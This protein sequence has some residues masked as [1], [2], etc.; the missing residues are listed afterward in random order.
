MYHCA[1]SRQNGSGMEDDHSSAQGQLNAGKMSPWLDSDG[2]RC[3][4][5]NGGAG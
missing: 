1:S 3:T 2:G 5:M 4:T